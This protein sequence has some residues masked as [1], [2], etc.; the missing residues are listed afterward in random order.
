MKRPE[1]WVLC[2]RRASLA[3]AKTEMVSG[4]PGVAPGPECQGGD[5]GLPSSQPPAQA[6][7]LH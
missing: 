6:S 5:K 7:D 4:V 2:G 3:E 1:G